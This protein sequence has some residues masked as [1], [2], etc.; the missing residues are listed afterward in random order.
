MG[1]TDRFRLAAL[2]AAFLLVSC[3]RQSTEPSP[4]RLASSAAG[5]E[6]A[7]LAVREVGLVDLGLGR[8]TRVDGHALTR[9]IPTG[10]A[11]GPYDDQA[12]AFVRTITGDEVHGGVTYRV[13][14]SVDPAE[15]AVT[16]LTDRWR[17]DRSGLFDWQEDLGA[18]ARRTYAIH[19]YADVDA[20]S[21]ERALAVI[22]AK[23]A[24][25]LGARGPLASEITFLRYPLHPHASWDGRPGFNVWYF[26]GWDDLDTPAGRFRAARVRIDVP[27][28]LRP[29][30][31]VLEWW[32][33]PGEIKRHFHFTADMTDASGQETGTFEADETLLVSAYTP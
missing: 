22:E 10:Q 5:L 29:D 11:P 6:A 19:A 23:R 33:A 3:S 14:T 15:P 18:P 27:G 25:V 12:L 24:A 21:L 32:A 1:P 9:I 17:Q 2:A 28:Q 16:L 7:P 31:V 26:E 4:L 13:E 30:D 20:A 8:V